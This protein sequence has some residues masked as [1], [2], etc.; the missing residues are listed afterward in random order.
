MSLPK[1]ETEK[2]AKKEKKEMKLKEIKEKLKDKKVMAVLLAVVVMATA[3]GGIVYFTTQPSTITV[4]TGVESFEQSVSFYTTNANKSIESLQVV[5]SAG[6]HNVTTATSP[7]LVATATSGENG[8]AFSLS[9]ANLTQGVYIIFNVTIK[10]T[11]A[12]NLAFAG[13]STLNQTESGTGPFYSWTANTTNTLAWNNG[14]GIGAVEGNYYPTYSIM[15]FLNSNGVG[16]FGTM[17]SSIMSNQT[18]DVMVSGP[19]TGYGSNTSNPYPSYIVPGGS[20]VYQIIIGLG[21]YAPISYLGQT[22]TLSFSVGP[23]AVSGST[24]TPPTPYPTS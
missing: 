12:G 21:T 16:D 23:Q 17:P 6:P 11:G 15:S 13:Y 22:Y 24:P 10:N 4:R 1:G 20:V 9:V 2:K 19:S 7:F 18:F 3:V 14:M 8:A 5:N